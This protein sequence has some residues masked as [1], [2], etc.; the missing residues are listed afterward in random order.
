MQPQ[1]HRTVSN[2]AKTNT[3]RHTSPGKGYE[4]ANV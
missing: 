1:Q 4:E 3:G 2:I